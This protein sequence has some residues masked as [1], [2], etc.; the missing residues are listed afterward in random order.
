MNAKLKKIIK[1]INELDPALSSAE[2]EKL[3]DGLAE[4]KPVVKTDRR[5]KKALKE[6]IVGRKH[7][8]RKLL[9]PPVIGAA[10]AALAAVVVL[11]VLV[12]SGRFAGRH[13][14]VSVAE[15]SAISGDYESSV[16]KAPAT[17]TESERDDLRGFKPEGPPKAEGQVTTAAN[18]ETTA[19]DK[20]GY[21]DRSKLSDNRK[22]VKLHFGFIS[23]TVKE[24]EKT[25]DL[26]TAFAEKLGGYVETAGVEL[27]VIRVP[28]AAFTAAMAEIATYGEVTDKSIETYDVT[29]AYEDLDLRLKVATQARDRLYQLLARTTDVKERFNILNEIQRLTEQ[30]EAIGRKLS[31]LDRLAAFSKI[32]VNLKPRVQASGSD[33]GAI[34]FAWIRE[35]T[36][37]KTEGKKLRGSVRV[38]WPVDFA[39]LEKEKFTYAENPFGVS[40]A[41]YTEE[42]KPRGD[43]DFWREAVAFHLQKRFASAT[44]LELGRFKAVLFQSNDSDPFYLLIG[45]YA[46]GDRLTVCKAVFPNKAQFGEQNAAVEKMIAGME[47]RP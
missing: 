33:N 14:S 47:V 25:R 18:K 34:P 15:Y 16:E 19:S 4:R 3:V 45:V 2:I 27:V 29:A 42:N 1:E 40:L 22:E 30:I 5:F 17:G 28:Q 39:L 43:A 24:P 8:L 11:F 38:E 23:L 21:F 46:A 9:R 6:K 26:I 44:R 20:F 36:S 7:G 32:S 35:A 10:A 12:G 31:S 37:L 41:V 13:G